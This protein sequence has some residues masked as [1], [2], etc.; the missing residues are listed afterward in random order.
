ML[1]MSSH[2][3]ESKNQTFKPILQYVTENYRR[4]LSL[5]DLADQF[6][7][8]PSYISQLFKKEVGETFTAY[9]ARLR[10]AQACEL[11]E[12]G[13]STVQDIAEKIGYRDYFYFTRLFKKLTGQ[14]P[15]QYRDAHPR[16]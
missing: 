12:R 1:Q 3:P 15:T 14:T 4:D 2:V 6:F 9:V 7:M 10:V 11:L 8:N 5:Q 16:D 13:D